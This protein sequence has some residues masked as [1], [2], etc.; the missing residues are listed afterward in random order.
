MMFKTS[1]DP[2]EIRTEEHQRRIILPINAPSDAIRSNSRL[3]LGVLPGMVRVRG[4][5]GFLSCC[6]GWLV[7]WL[8]GLDLLLIL[9]AYTLIA[10]FPFDFHSVL[11]TRESKRI[12]FYP[13]HHN[14]LLRSVVAI[15]L[16]VFEEAVD[17][18]LNNFDL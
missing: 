8:V 1:K 10:A 4:V 14:L 15:F 9:Y 18:E 12:E 17:L 5:K 11:Y 3:Y 6:V 16:E 7:G 13:L 2:R